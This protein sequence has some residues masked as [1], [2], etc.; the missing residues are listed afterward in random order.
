MLFSSQSTGDPVYRISSLE[1]QLRH[2]QK[3]LTES[4]RKFEAELIKHHLS[5]RDTLEMLDKEHKSDMNEAKQKI[6]LLEKKLEEMEKE[7]QTIKVIASSPTNS[8]PSG[9]P[10]LQPKSPSRRRK[11]LKKGDSLTPNNSKSELASALT[12][13]LNKQKT[14]SS[15]T[16]ILGFKDRPKSSSYGDLTEIAKGKEKNTSDSKL[17]TTLQVS[18]AS[19]RKEGE[20]IM[21]RRESGD[22]LTITAL[23]AE[24]M[25]N[26]GSIAAIRKELKSDS[27]TPKIQRKFPNRPSGTTN[28]LLSLSPKNDVEGAGEGK[29]GKSPLNTRRDLFEKIKRPSNGT[30]II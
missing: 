22:R 21:I 10:S 6:E 27:F 16:D 24:S 26:P 15:D 17:P 12:P 28:V 7:K 5:T 9:P 4:H 23:V 14:A 1:G 11:R 18:P 30:D 8:V 29:E 19:A 20:K 13:P 25:S 3:K 2:C